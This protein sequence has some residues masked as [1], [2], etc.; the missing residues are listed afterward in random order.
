MTVRDDPFLTR[1]PEPAPPRAGSRHPRTAHAAASKTVSSELNR[2]YRT[3]QI[4]RADYQRYSRSLTSALNAEGR[5]SGT[6]ASELGAV[7]SNL[8]WIAASSQLT[9]SRLPVLFLTLD[10]NRQWWTSS[11]IP[12]SG[13]LIEFPGSQLVWEYYSGQGL[14]LQPLATFGR[15]DGFYTAGRSKYPALRSLLAEMIPLAAQRAGAIVWEYY[16]Y[17]GGGSPPWVSAMAQGTALEALT[18]AQKAFGGS[19]LAI[20]AR[21]L[22]LFTAGPPA[23]VRVST[24]RGARYLQ[25]S[26]ESGTDIINAFLQSL[27]GL[28]DYAQVSGSPQAAQLFA[29]GDAQAQAELPGFDTGAWSLYQYG[30]EDSLSYHELVTGFLDQLCTR[31]QAPAYCTTAQHFTAYLTTPP[32]LQLLTGRVKF[33]KPSTIRFRLSKV[34]HVGIVVVRGTQT[35][36]ATSAGFSH[37]VNSFSI[38]SLTH[39]GTYTVRMSA[40]DLAGNFGQTEGTVQVS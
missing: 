27:I 14:E 25:Y 4:S 7:L 31:T 30:L 32:T 38:P 19:Y 1:P 20:G 39:R 12:S 8:H 37:G 13:S 36:I 40:T 23:G 22:P 28:Y 18:R 3:R 26:F 2:L 16:F 34:S 33:K 10:R 35:V 17:F 15:A 24:R 29:A 5:L 9:P 11:S 6:R 21:A